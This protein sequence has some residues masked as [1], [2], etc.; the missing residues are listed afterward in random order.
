MK[1]I[2]TIAAVLAVMAA[3][4]FAADYGWTISSSST[5]PFVNQGN[6]SAAPTTLYLW[7]QCNANDGMSAAEFDVAAPAGY[8]NFGFTPMNGFLNAAGPSDP[9]LAVGSCPIGPVL[10][11]SWTFFGS[12]PGSICLVPSARS[13]WS[14]TVDCD[15]VAPQVHNNATIGYGIGGPASCADAQP[16]CG[17]VAVEPSSWGSVKSLYR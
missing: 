14:V 12:T 5:D 4:A 7:Y 10:A 15:P 13:G 8:L 17:P 9:L 2:L 11:G 1:R 3:P 6:V 16:L